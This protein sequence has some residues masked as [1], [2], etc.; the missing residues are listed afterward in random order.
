MAA[1]PLPRLRKLCLGLPDAHE[2]EAWGA[3]TFRIRNRLFA[4]Y[5]APDHGKDEIRPAV[6][7]VAGPGN[8]RLM[9]ESNPARFFVPPYV[10][11]SGWVGIWLDR[12][13]P[14][15]AIEQLIRDAY[16]I[17]E[18]KGP[19]RKPSQAKKKKRKPR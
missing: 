18:A 16:E 9:V 10:G 12:R 11:P 8:Q 17:I 13:P 4:M 15:K 14:W 2:V 3:P 7:C 1:D 5:S 19:G 6:W